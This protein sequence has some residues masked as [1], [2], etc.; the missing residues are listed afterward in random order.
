MG[1]PRVI[2]ICH[3]YIR[4]RAMYAVA[5]V[6]PCVCVCVHGTQKPTTRNVQII[7]IKIQDKHICVHT[8]LYAIHIHLPCHPLFF[9]SVCFAFVAE[10]LPWLNRCGIESAAWSMW[11]MYRTARTAYCMVCGVRAF[12]VCFTMQKREPA[13]DDDD[14]NSDAVTQMIY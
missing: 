1:C 3:I 5:C 7:N 4:L 9:L 6:S 12:F 10:I 13:D 2:S 14:D 8:V 11:S